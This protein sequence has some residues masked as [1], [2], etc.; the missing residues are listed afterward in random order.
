MS[1]SFG[2]RPQRETG[3]YLG[4]VWEKGRLVGNAWYRGGKHLI[5]IGPNGTGKGTG[6]IVPALK[7]LRRSI[8]IIDPKGEAAA[9]TARSRAR[10]GRVVILNP[11]N[12][13]VDRCPWLKS[14]GFNPL[15]ALDPKSRHFPEAATGIAEAL[16]KLD[17]K[18][19]HFAPSAQELVSALTMFECINAATRGIAP[20]LGNVRRMLTEP[21]A[22]SAEANPTGLLDTAYKMLATDYEPLQAKAG[23][24]VQPSREIQ[25]I[26][27]TGITATRSLDSPAITADLAQGDFDFADMKREII[28]VYLIMPANYLETNSSWL[29]LMVVSALRALLQGP[30]SPTLPPVLFM[31]DEF[32]QL[33]YLSPIEN[34]MGIARGFGVQ[35]WP[36]LQDLNQLKALYRDRWE[37]F[38][39]ARGALTAFAPQD[40]FTAEYLAKLCGQTTRVVESWNQ[41]DD[42]QGSGRDGRNWAP[43]GL[44]LFRPEELM[45][46]GANRMLCL[47]ESERGE[48]QQPFITLAPGYWQTPYRAGLDPNP[49]FA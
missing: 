23:R 29:R 21:Y 16:V 25:S 49:Y 45:R 30:P 13:L 5:T 39:G 2:F 36:F 3:I 37:T 43:Q 27:S 32:A 24:F 33:G 17:P 46:L 14:H 6:I 18:D 19:P 44:P 10:F 41:S 7:Q 40:W 35:L 1:W 20:T 22:S 8:L 31:L 4:Q 26:I 12:V 38:I 11:F 48:L 15:A 28:T 42:L 47:V 9:I 34:A